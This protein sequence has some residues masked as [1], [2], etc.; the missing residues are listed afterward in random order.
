ME[1]RVNDPPEPAMSVLLPTAT[2]FEA[3]RRTVYALARQTIADR[4]ELIIIA[5][6]DDPEIDPAAVTRFAAV[7]VVVL[8]GITSSNGARMAGLR[9]ARAPIVVMAEDHSFPEPAWAEALLAAY[10]GDRVAVGP[11]LRNGNWRTALS[12]GNYLLEYGPWMDGPAGERAY[13][14]GHNSSY[15]RAALLALGDA[16]PELL[17]AESVAQDALR[18]RGGRLYLEPAAVTHHWGFSRWPASLRLRFLSGRHFAGHRCQRWPMGRRLLYIAGAPLIPVVR[19]RRILPLTR[20]PQL[21]HLPRWRVIP[22]LL[23]LLVLDGLG[24]L[25]GYIAGPGSSTRALAAIE[26]E[27]WRFMNAAD[28]TAF[29]APEADARAVATAARAQRPAAAAVAPRG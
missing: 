27:R 17:E 24:E 16:L 18:A 1:S 23:S 21:A 29:Q 25:T 15:D 28:R 12:W 7:Q 8:D 10:G 5:P 4:L 14:P 26:F 13:L 2:G 9:A 20:A 6:T 19:L 3:I 22:A 11:V